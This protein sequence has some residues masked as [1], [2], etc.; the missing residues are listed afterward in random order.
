MKMIA[1]IAA[2][3]TS[4]IAKLRQMR[5]GFC[6]SLFGASFMFKDIGFRRPSSQEPIPQR[7]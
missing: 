3:K 5:R 7:F 6:E 2:Q 1:A 4:Q